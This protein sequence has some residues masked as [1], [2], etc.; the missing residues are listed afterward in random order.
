MF[1]IGEKVAYVGYPDTPSQMIEPQIRETVTIELFKNSPHD[2]CLHVRIKEYQFDKNSYNQYFYIG[3][4]RKLDH[5]FAE[6]ITAKIEEEINQE[7]LVG[8]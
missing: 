4:I 1:K 5:T 6:E 7:N 2:G 8:V 3:A